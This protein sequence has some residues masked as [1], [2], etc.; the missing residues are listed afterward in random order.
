MVQKNMVYDSPSLGIME[1]ETEQLL[2]N[3]VGIEQPEEDDMV[4]WDFE[5]D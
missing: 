2:A 3:S 5:L 1:I 4:D